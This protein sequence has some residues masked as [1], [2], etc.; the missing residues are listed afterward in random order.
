[1][2]SNKPLSEIDSALQFRFWNNLFGIASLVYGI[3][4]FYG[5]S[6]EI[7][8]FIGVLNAVAAIIFFH[9]GYKIKIKVS[10]TLITVTL[11]LA[12]SQAIWV[13]SSINS[14]KGYLTPLPF[15]AVY[16]ALFPSYRL[17][18]LVKNNEHHNIKSKD[19]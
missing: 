2:L 10:L 18:K 6:T 11:I 19:Q 17:Y 8:K 1:M 3:G 7:N 16:L 13:A 14:H 15:L 9:N 12:L 5:W 4:I